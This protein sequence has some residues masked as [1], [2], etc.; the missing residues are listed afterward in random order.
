MWK[1]IKSKRKQLKYRGTECLNCKHPLDLSDRYCPKCSQINSTKR[2]TFLD[3]IR[4]FFDTI[5]SYDSKFRKTIW[6]MFRYPGKITKE[7]TLGKRMNYSNP[8][9]FFLSISFLY[10]IILLLFIDLWQIDDFVNDKSQDIF[11]KIPSTEAINDSIEKEL[12]DE[13][14]ETREKAK[15]FITINSAN[16]KKESQEE[17]EKEANQDSVQQI[18][19]SIHYFNAPKF[20]D[21][22]SQ[23]V[24][25]IIKRIDFKADAFHYGIKQ[26]K[27]YSLDNLLKDMRL[28][29]SWENQISYKFAFNKHRIKNSPSLYISFIINKLPFVI[30]F[31]VPFLAFFIWL[32]YSKKKFLYMDH[33]VFCYQTLTILILSILIWTLVT[34]PFGESSFSATLFLILYFYNIIYLYKA[35]RRFYDQSRIKTFIKYVYINTFFS[36][37]AVL[38]ISIFALISFIMY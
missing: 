35:M 23:N 1:K 30:F 22:I 25:R 12:A 28:P 5:F 29:H 10:I 3:L 18:K 20:F 17:A 16:K 8:F 6:V 15:Q 14:K 4:D 36:I 27:I 31:T 34:L 26:K 37:L 32:I 38:F 19:D 24:P 11:G 33:M 13:D 7:F 9:R 2:I 21:S